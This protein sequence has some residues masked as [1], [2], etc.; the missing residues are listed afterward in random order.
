MN[1]FLFHI[2]RYFLLIRDLF[3]SWERPS[4]YYKLIL[5]EY[6]SMAIGS[7]SIVVLISTFV[8]GV[9]TLQTSYQL[10]SSWI[11]R[12]TIGNIVSAST[13]LELSPTVVTF[14][15]AGRIGS[16]IASQ[17]GTMRVTEQIDALEVMG[18]NPVAYLVLPKIIAAFFA[19]P[20]MVTISAFLCHF[21]G[22]VAGELSGQLSKEDFMLGVQLWYDPFQVTV[23]YTKSLIFGFLISSISAYH[24]FFTHGGALEVGQSSTK[25][26]VYSCMAVVIADYLVAQI[27]L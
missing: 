21:G 6:N 26:V 12:Y 15:L 25:A 18:V 7:L 13:L 2:G 20:T 4:V 1:K 3:R 19:F 11:P 8:G 5:D 23:M 24:G 22:L 9:T 14:I 27:M 10:V 16:S 17:I